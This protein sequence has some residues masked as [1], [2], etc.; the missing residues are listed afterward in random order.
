MPVTT[1]THSGPRLHRRAATLC[2]VLL[3][4]STSAWAAPWRSHV[5]LPSGDEVQLRTQGRALRPAGSRAE[6]DLP[7]RVRFSAPVASPVGPVALADARLRV[8]CKEGTVSASA[9]VPRRDGGRTFATKGHK[10]AVAA[11]RAPL[12]QVVSAPSFVDSLC[13]R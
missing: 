7:V 13:R 4:L 1:T 11:A 9:V 8:H 6:I 10:A 5:T 12:L 2:T 3:V